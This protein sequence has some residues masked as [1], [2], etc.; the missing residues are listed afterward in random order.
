MQ[1][2]YVLVPVKRSMAKTVTAIIFLVLAVSFL[3]MTCVMPIVAPI[4]IAFLVLGGWLMFR[5][6]KE[7]EYSYFDGEFR[8]AKIMNKSRRKRLGVYSMDEVI[9]I[10][11]EHDRSV[12]NY[13]ND[14]MIPVKDYTS[15]EGEHQVYDLV[16]QKDG[17]MVL[18]KFEPDAKYLDTVE[19][20]FKQKVVRKREQ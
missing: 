6:Y 2:I 20:K 13:E 10:A 5:S 9:I 15:H 3:L 16:A 18:I 17:N 8:F 14:K 7:Y 1:E 19:I 12:N 4:G 11:P